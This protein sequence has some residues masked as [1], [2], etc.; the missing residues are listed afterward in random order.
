MAIRCFRKNC[1]LDFQDG[2]RSSVCNSTTVTVRS[3]Y[4]FGFRI[5]W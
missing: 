3:F 2:F 5:V 1:I 4:G